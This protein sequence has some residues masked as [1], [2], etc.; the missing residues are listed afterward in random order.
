M[1]DSAFLV[2]RILT[3]STAVDSANAAHKSNPPIAPEVT[4][5]F[6][7]PDNSAWRASGLAKAPTEVSTKSLPRE[8]TAGPCSFAAATPAH[9]TTISWASMSSARLSSHS[10]TPRVP[11]SRCAAASRTN[12]LTSNS[13]GSKSDTNWR[14]IAPKPRSNTRGAEA[15]MTILHYRAV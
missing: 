12:A 4:C 10:D 5:T 15:D 11:R 14:P 3:V 1:R 13:D 9:S 8:I 6:P 7:G 2:V